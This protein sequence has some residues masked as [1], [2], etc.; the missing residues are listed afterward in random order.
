M[1][2]SRSAFE[3]RYGAFLPVQG[4]YANKLGNDGERVELVGVSGATIAAFEYNDIWYRDTDGGGKSLSLVDDSLAGANYGSLA[5]WGSSGSDGGTPGAV[6]DVVPGLRYGDWLAGFFDAGQMADPA[7][8]GL[9]TDVDSDGLVALVEY[10]LGLDPSVGSG[11]GRPRASLVDAGGSAYA[12]LEFRR[13]K[14]ATD[15]GYRVE[16][17]ANLQDWE[18]GDVEVG[19]PVDNGDGTE[20]VTVRDG[21][22]LVDGEQRY[23]RLV[24]ELR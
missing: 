14:A 12:A 13:Q 7:V 10:G 20:T 1:V 21:A 3:R 6:N 24:V 2:E 23:L 11:A 15:V 22:P 16:V 9:G 18:V 8:T 4:E 5:S 19:A 17:S